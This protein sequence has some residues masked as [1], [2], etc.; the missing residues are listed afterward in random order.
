M[1]VPP[2]LNLNWVTEIFATQPLDLTASS[3]MLFTPYLA[4]A[5]RARWEMNS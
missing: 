2:E 1:I 3:E 5:S 4:L